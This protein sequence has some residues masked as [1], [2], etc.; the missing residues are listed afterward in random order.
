VVIVVRG[1]LGQYL[2]E[3]SSP[4][5]KDP[6]GALSANGA[7]ESLGECVRSWRSNGCLE[8]TAP[9]LGA[10]GLRRKVT[11]V[12]DLSPYTSIDRRVTLHL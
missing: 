1:V 5:D 7:D 11:V 10:R 3:M 9:D 8:L 12:W 4:E 2:L 6:I